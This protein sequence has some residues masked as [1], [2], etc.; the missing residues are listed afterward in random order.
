MVA[1][2]F[3]RSASCALNG[4]C[5]PAMSF[6]PPM[7]A[8]LRAII[9]CLEREKAELSCQ[10]ASQTNELVKVRGILA[11]SPNLVAT[12]F[13]E[14]ERE[15]KHL[16]AV[17]GA[18]HTDFNT[19][20][21]SMMLM[22]LSLFKEQIAELKAEKE[23]IVDD[24]A[25]TFQVNV[26]LCSLL[27]KAYRE[28]G[29]L[30]TSASLAHHANLEGSLR[31]IMHNVTVAHAG[32]DVLRQFAIE[33]DT[34]ELQALLEA[35]NCPLE[36][37]LMFLHEVL[38]ARHLLK[39]S[40]TFDCELVAHCSLQYFPLMDTMVLGHM[41]CHAFPSFGMATPSPQGTIVL[42]T[43]SS[44]GLVLSKRSVDDLD[45]DA[46]DIEGKWDVIDVKRPELKHSSEA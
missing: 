37:N 15:T 33:A 43:N 46:G 34:P 22:L 44:S 4:M 28:V 11:E 40:Y 14:L 42:P 3:L 36:S 5:H 9:P 7:E 29:T 26:A 8:E 13:S 10:V 30:A 32:S 25:Q 12:H 16:E 1:P 2:S 31:V 35:I 39:Q 21:A 18:T 23:S 24:L 41:V 19:F 6:Q 27:E 20:K 17:Q 38:G 45:K